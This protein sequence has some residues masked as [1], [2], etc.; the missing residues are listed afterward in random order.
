MAL[1]AE[2]E[3]APLTADGLTIDLDLTTIIEANN[4]AG[5]NTSS[6]S[7]RNSNTDGKSFSNSD[8]HSEAN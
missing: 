2:V 3:E 1:K 6:K 4:H 8:S 5:S 7:R